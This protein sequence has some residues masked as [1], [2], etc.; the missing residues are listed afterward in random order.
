M[1]KYILLASLLI[2]SLV[3]QCQSITK[4]RNYVWD[5]VIIKEVT[6][7]GPKYA[8]SN[9]RIINWKGTVQPFVYL[10]DSSK[11]L[12][13]IEEAEVPV[14]PKPSVDIYSYT[15]IKLQDD[16]LRDI[17]IK[18][19]YAVLYNYKTGNLIRLESEGEKIVAKYFDVI[20]D[21]QINDDYVL[22]FKFPGD[23]FTYEKNG[24][25]N[26]VYSMAQYT[27]NAALS[28]D[29]YLVS[30]KDGSRK[31]I[32]KDL[33]PGVGEFP[34][35]QLSSDNKQ[36]KYFQPPNYYTYTISTGA[37]LKEQSHPP[38]EVVK[39]FK[40]TLSKSSNSIIQTEEFIWKAFDGKIAKGVLAKPKDFDP[41]KKYPIIF[42]YY[43]SSV[44]RHNDNRP[45]GIGDFVDY[46]YLV[47][48]PNIKYKIGETGLS[49]FN[50][51]VS[52]AEHMK[53]LPYVDGT[54]MGLRGASFGGFETNY[55]VT[56]SNLFAAAIS[57]AGYSD[58]I[59][60]IGAI[61][62]FQR[63]HGLEGTDQNRLG[64]TMWQR[65][66]IWIKNSPI[67]YAD[68]VTSPLLL[69]HSKSDGNV[70]FEQ[71]LG[72][73]KA[74]RSLGKRSWLLQYDDAGHIGLNTSIVG[75]MDS[76]C[77][78]CTRQLQFF[79]HY[80]KGEP[81][82]KWMLN[83]IPARQKGTFTGLE[84]D[85]TGITPGRGLRRD[86]LILSVQQR[87][88][89]KQQTEVTNEGRVK[90]VKNSGKSTIMSVDKIMK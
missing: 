66:D 62:N 13:Y 18:R 89:L 83:G 81:A 80:L 14:T 56:H 68:R 1:N 53:K 30:L 54:K 74:L 44:I 42:V 36:V 28:S 27:W 79:N 64:V 85:S 19:K 4:D 48:S 57:M 37:T 7:L 38:K 25:I 17:D 70:P 60:N 52:A 46:G 47:F 39:P 75:K 49:V 58:F 76:N 69:I 24:V 9:D 3:V 50:Y 55:L 40:N 67:F 35:V 6:K 88:L 32:K 15:D 29:L 33:A 16:Q 43:E 23:V 78:F 10:M 61:N 11:V 41:R 22:L 20:Y 73:F 77:D 51:V 26:E 8:I 82:P 31:V 21:L 45:Y 71:S 86:D 5:E 59:S 87:E 2:L 84:L 34:F 12:F 65:P 90:E 63:P 72:F